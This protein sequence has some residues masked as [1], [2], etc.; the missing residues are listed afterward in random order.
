MKFLSI[1]FFLLISYCFA[2]CEK[3]TQKEIIGV[4]IIDEIHPINNN[5]HKYD[6]LSNFLQFTINECQFPKTIDRKEITGKWNIQKEMKKTYLNIKTERKEFKG[7]YLVNFYIDEKGKTHMLM[8]S[9][10]LIMSCTKFELNFH[11]I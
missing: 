10:R 3:N 9:E 4:W 11:T 2:S 8:E 1:W 7:K 5:N 6:M